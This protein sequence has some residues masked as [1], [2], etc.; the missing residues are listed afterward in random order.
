MALL[1]VKDLQVSYGLIRAIKGVSFQVQKGEI[2]SLI[3][4]N[5]AGKTTLL[6]MLGG[7]DTI[8]GGKILFDGKDIS[9]LGKRELI[10]Y[11][12]HEV[13]FVFQFYNLIPNLTAL[14]NVEIAAQL[15]SDP[16]P[17]EEVLQEVGLGERMPT[18]CPPSFPAVNS[19][20]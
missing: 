5:G 19:S 20:G 9:H 4:A 7:M 3:G 12:R 18:A 13:G 17:A 16:I 8:T 10:E 6:N 11:R 15:C 1:E 14:E 2:V